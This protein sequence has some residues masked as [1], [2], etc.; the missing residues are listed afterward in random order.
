METGGRSSRSCIRSCVSAPCFPL[1][2]LGSP[3]VAWI[4][5]VAGPRSSSHILSALWAFCCSQPIQETHTGSPHP[6]TGPL[7]SAR[8]V[9]GAGSEASGRREPL[10][11]PH[12]PSLEGPAR[13]TCRA[14]LAETR[15]A[16]RCFQCLGVPCLVRPVWGFFR[17]LPAPRACLRT[18]AA[19]GA[20]GPTPHLLGQRRAEP[21]I[22]TSPGGSWTR[23]S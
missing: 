9:P 14:V 19:E 18:V 7:C 22:R 16:G 8:A 20:V 17:L 23:E 3:R 11:A 12:T 21:G 4:R 10:P 5:D 2:H 1:V 6:L 15:R 13:P